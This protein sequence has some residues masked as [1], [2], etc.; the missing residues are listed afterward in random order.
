MRP[1]KTR[2]S[3]TKTGFRR[4]PT[5]CARCSAIPSPGPLIDDY[6]PRVLNRRGEAATHGMRFSLARRELEASWG[7]ANLEVPLSEVCQ[8]DGFFWFVSHLLAQLPRYRQVHNDALDEYR[9][10]HG[11]RSKNHPVAALR[12]QGE[13]LEAPFWVWRGGQPRRRALLVR[14]RSREM[15]LRIAGEDEV[16]L[17]LPLAPE[18]EACCAVERLR[19]LAGRS[20]RL[21]HPRPDDDALQPFSARRSVHSRDRRRQV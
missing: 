3:W 5:A 16:L 8:T 9:A 7:V 17:E 20:V 18:R 10:A 14:Q 13:W 1:L 11:I 15:D 21:A 2:R 12:R 4:S 19:E 6:W